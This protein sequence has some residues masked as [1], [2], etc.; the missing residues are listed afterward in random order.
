MR[1]LTAKEAKALKISEQVKEQYKISPDDMK[2]EIFDLECV[3]MW[4]LWP[5][6]PMKNVMWRHIDFR[7]PWS[8]I[9]VAIGDN[10][11]NIEKRVYLVGAFDLKEQG[12]STT[13][14][15]RD[16]VEFLEY[17]TWEQMVEDGWRVD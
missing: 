12:L 11:G 1:K 17:A 4:P 13:H 14:D 15:I 6:M 9:V 10:D 8:A 16:K 5:I 3:D 2:R 7:L